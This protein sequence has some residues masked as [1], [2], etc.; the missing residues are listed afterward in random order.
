MLSST[1][2]APHLTRFTVWE[3]SSPTTGDRAV[4][5][6]PYHPTDRL[7]EHEYQRILAQPLCATPKDALMET[8]R[9]F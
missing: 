1:N 8:T 9:V 4:V 3:F 7:Y 6:R 2:T 5:V